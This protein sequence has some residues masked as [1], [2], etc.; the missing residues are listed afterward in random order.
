MSEVARILPLEP[1]E[2]L[3]AHLERDGGTALRAAATVSPGALIDEIEAS[4]LRGRGGAGFP[5]GRKWRAVATA[6]AD[7]GPP[8]V[9]VTVADGELGELK[10]R[11][12]LRRNPYAVLEGAVLAARAIRADEVVFAVPPTCDAEAALLD[13]A[14]WEVGRAGWTTDAELSIVS[15][16]GEFV[17]GYTQQGV[18][19]VPTLPLVNNVETIANVPGIIGNG[20]AWFRSVGT[21][22]SPGTVV[23]AVTGS[24][25]RHAVG[26]VAMG[27]PL[28]EVISA[29]GGDPEPGRRVVGVMSEAASALVP[30]SQLDIPLS[31]E[32]LAGVGSALGIAAFIV[33]DD[34]RAA[35]STSARGR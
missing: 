31:Y 2:G 33:F 29:I 12:I 13:I 28:R 34:V 25:R 7:A 8:R 3:A 23:C 1:V 27:T 30:E 22:E 4:G 18:G 11:T 35:D 19:R 17:Y 14:I 32:G 21:D 16:G 26:E 5:T 24:S 9:I 15:D 6:P 10:D 20:A